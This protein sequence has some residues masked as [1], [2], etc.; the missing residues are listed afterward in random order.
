MTSMLEWSHPAAWLANLPCLA[1]LQLAAFDPDTATI[2]PPP[3]LAAPSSIAANGQAHRPA[4]CP[5]PTDIDKVNGRNCRSEK[6]GTFINLVAK[7]GCSYTMKD[8]WL[9]TF[10]TLVIAYLSTEGT[11]QPGY[12][13][14]ALLVRGWRLRS[15]GLCL[16]LCIPLSLHLFLRL[17]PC[18]CLR[19]RLFLQLCLCLCNPASMPVPVRAPELHLFLGLCLHMQQ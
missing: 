2:P 15:S 12:A 7:A 8:L 3:H 18:L 9:I 17:C 10:T 6:S 11:G 13:H 1:G 4:V 19:I 14:D 5:T 16:C